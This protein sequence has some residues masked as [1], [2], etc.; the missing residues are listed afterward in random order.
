[1][2]QSDFEIIQIAYDALNKV[3]KECKN[4]EIKPKV[5]INTLGDRSTLEIYNQKLL[6]FY[7]GKFEKLSKE[8]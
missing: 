4:A 2:V 7:E 6:Q 3:I 8:S 1:M 5:Y